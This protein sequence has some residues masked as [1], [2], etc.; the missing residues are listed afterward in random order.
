MAEHPMHPA[1]TPAADQATE[2]AASPLDV[3]S[4]NRVLRSEALKKR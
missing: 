1:D 4:G 3:R 2:R